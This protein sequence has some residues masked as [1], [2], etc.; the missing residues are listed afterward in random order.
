[1]WLIIWGMFVV[2]MLSWVSVAN[3]EARRPTPGGE[4]EP[5]PEP[6]RRAIQALVD[7]ATIFSGLATAGAV[8]VAVVTY[9]KSEELQRDVAASA[10]WR[11]YLQLA[12]EHPDLANVRLHADST[13]RKYP[14]FVGHVL[15]A[16]EIILIA[17][18]DDSGWRETVLNNLCLHKAHIRDTKE[19]PPEEYGGIMRFV[20]DSIQSGMIC[21]DSIP[22][23]AADSGATAP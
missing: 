2:A 11:D 10:V 20:V 15:H 6:R 12:V 16:S 5:P 7:I 1:M 14:W 13:R 4:M 23:G 3:L 22:S 17:H 19:V 18:P 21:P 8:V 9:R